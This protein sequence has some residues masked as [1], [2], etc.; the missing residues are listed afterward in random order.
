M[1]TAT[2][3]MEW[4]TSVPTPFSS[5]TRRLR[6]VAVAGGVI[7][8]LVAVF[9]AEGPFALTFDDAYYY[10]EIARRIADGQGSTFDGIAET[11]GYHPLWMAIC[12]IP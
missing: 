10:F 3:A 5:L 4:N 6:A 7:Y 2:A 11:N 12:T 8:T 1:L 9:W